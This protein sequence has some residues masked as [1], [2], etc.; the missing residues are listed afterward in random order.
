MRKLALLVAVSAVLG[1]CQQDTKNL[2]RKIDELNKNVMAVLAR[3]GGAG[4][5]QQRPQLSLIHI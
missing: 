2:E 1:A 3:G 5:A 4:A